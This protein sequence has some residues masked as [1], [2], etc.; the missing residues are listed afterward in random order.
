MTPVSALLHD[1]TRGVPTVAGLGLALAALLAPPL[2][3]F[4]PAGM[5][6]L[7]ALVMLACNGRASLAAARSYAAVLALLALISAWGAITAF[8][9]PIP[10]HSLLE[11]GR[12]LLLATGGTLVLGQAAAL[13]YREAARLGI[14]LVAGIVI[15]VLLLQIELR[16]HEAITR[17]LI[18]VPAARLAAAGLS[19]YDRGI[20]VLLLLAWPAAV[21]LAARRHW[22]GVALLAVAVGVTVS[23]FNSRA[24][25]LALVIGVAVASL[26]A[27][28]P[29]LVAFGLVGGVVLVASVFPAV[30]PDGGGVNRIR[31]ALPA[32]PESAIPRLEIWRFVAERIGDRPI[33]GWGMDASRAVPGGKSL[34]IDLYPEVKM[35]DR[36]EAL[37]LHPHNAA[38]QWRLELG[39]PGTLL[40]L[41]T[42][43]LMLWRVAHDRTRAGWQ[44]ALAFGY[45]AACLTMALLSFGAWQAWWLSTLWLGAALV[46]RL[47]ET[48]TR[49]AA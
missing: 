4:A 13:D 41:A 21:A 25:L 38:L 7:V 24:A 33:L 20:T 39:L 11:S 40:A 34:V 2:S 32:L 47:G 8:W 3:V 10:G 43:A 46:V 17:H 35:N 27:S 44:H 37:P 26:A 28:R 22:L 9:S 1:G 16:S 5:A 42:L 30:A 6:P 18:G 31:A 48:R 36:A 15:A 23:E 14:A 19:R 12:F 49:A 45:A 29:R